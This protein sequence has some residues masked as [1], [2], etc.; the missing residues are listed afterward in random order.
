MIN[1]YLVSRIK[2]NVTTLLD[3][4]LLL[5]HLQLSQINNMITTEFSSLIHRNIFYSTFLQVFDDFLCLVHLGNIGNKGLLI[6]KYS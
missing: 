5:K 3:K 2:H 4:I 1:M 6:N